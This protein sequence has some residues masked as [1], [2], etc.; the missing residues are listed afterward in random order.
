MFVGA[1]EV[2]EDVGGMMVA[3]WGVCFE[4]SGVG[5]GRSGWPRPEGG[6][7]AG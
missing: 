7:D 5:T 3:E 2:G 6:L 1:K 4:V